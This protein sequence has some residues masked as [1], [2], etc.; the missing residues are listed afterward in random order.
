[1][2]LK[3]ETKKVETAG[4]TTQTASVRGLQRSREGIV[5]S[6]KMDKTVVVNISRK[7]MHPAYGKFVTKSTRCFAHDEKNECNVGDK[8]E[9]VECRPLSRHKN[10][11]VNKIIERGQED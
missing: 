8:V 10:W 11:K 9:I 6:N 2:A 1:M 7:S 3:K 4:A 5:V